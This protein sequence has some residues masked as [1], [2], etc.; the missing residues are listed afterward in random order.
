LERPILPPGASPG[1]ERLPELFLKNAAEKNHADPRLAPA[2]AIVDDA[3]QKARDRGESARMVNTV[4]DS[5]R[6]LVAHRI[7]TGAALKEASAPS[8]D[9]P[10][11]PSDRGMDRSRWAR[12]SVRRAR[13]AAPTQPDP[14]ANPG[15]AR[16]WP[17]AWQER[18]PANCA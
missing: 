2:Q 8:P 7:K 5:T 10:A 12:S 6:Q 18:R 3:M 13:L 14:R 16:R 1:Q 4:G 17:L 15:G 9:Q 11:Q